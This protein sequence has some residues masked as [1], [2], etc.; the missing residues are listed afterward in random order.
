MTRSNSRGALG[1]E[2]AD[3]PRRVA[4]SKETLTDSV[5]IPST[6]SGHTNGTMQSVAG[7]T[8]DAEMP[9]FNRGFRHWPIIVG[10]CIANFQASLEN[11]VVVASGPTIVD[12][13]KMGEECIWITN[14]FFVCWYVGYYFGR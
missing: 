8:G 7:T 1:H 2:V 9:I 13:L 11:S 10:L 14:A 3:S 4:T 12:D 6:N 5:H